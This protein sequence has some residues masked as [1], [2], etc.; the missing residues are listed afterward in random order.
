MSRAYLLGTGLH[1]ALGADLSRQLAALRLPPAPPRSLQRRALGLSLRLPYQLLSETP[2]E[3]IE[4]RL[5]RVLAP[6]VQQ[7]LSEAALTP[8]QIQR[9]ALLVGS[10]SFDISMQE[11]YYQ[12]ALQ[13]DP[14][15]SPLRN[16]SYA[17][18]AAWLRGRFALR[19]EDYSFSTA[20]T[21]SANA[22]LYGRA[23]IEAGEAEHA[24][25]VGIEV[26][27]DTTLLGFRGLELIA[28]DG[29]RPFDAARNGLVLGEGCGAVVLGRRESG[30]P[31]HYVRGGANLCDTH[32]ISAPQ[33]DGGT[34]AAVIEQALADSDLHPG[35]IHTVKVHG[36][37]S[38]SNDEA[39]AAGLLRVFESMPTLCALKPYIGHTLGA[40]GLNELILMQGALAAGFVPATPGIG[41]APEAL[42]VRLNQA[43]HPATPGHCMLNYFGFGGNNSSIVISHIPGP[44]P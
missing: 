41:A 2:L 32:S 9:M 20:C 17:N 21:A 27:N 36:T 11:Q 25:V 31:G 35:D 12:Q 13:H 42:G 6:V 34:V 26:Y 18:I 5:L 19:G 37:A 4:T 8:A 10:S 7:A 24:L 29:M 44:A 14:S 3:D 23:L 38:L 16:C 33:P 43:V 1:T 39:E 15:A 40:C 22:L 30:A 28:S